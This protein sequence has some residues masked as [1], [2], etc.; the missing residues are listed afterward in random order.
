MT[1]I[2]KFPPEHISLQREVRRHPDLVALLNAR[3]PSDMAEWYSEIATYCDVLVDGLY[4]ARDFLNLSRLLTDK[5]YEKR[6][7]IVRR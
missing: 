4:D 3:R 6:T 2:L 5:L 1:E 7:L